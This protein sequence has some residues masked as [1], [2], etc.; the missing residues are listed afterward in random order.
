MIN[1]EDYNVKPM[2]YKC[3]QW[4]NNHFV[5]PRFDKNPPQLVK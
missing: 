1:E 2:E 3:I 4:S 5:Q